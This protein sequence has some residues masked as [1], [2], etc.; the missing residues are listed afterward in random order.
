[1]SDISKADLSVRVVS[2]PAQADQSVFVVNQKVVSGTPTAG[3]VPV[4]QSDGTLAWGGPYAALAVDNTF[5]GRQ[6][7][8][9][10]S[11]AAP[12]INFAGHLTTGISYMN[13]SGSQGIFVAGNGS[14]RGVFIG[15]TD[16]GSAASIV[17]Q[18]SNRLNVTADQG[19]NVTGTLVLS[20]ADHIELEGKTPAV[21]MKGYVYGTST[22][23]P[24]EV[25]TGGAVALAVRAFGSSPL[26]EWRDQNRNVQARSRS[27][28]DLE[29]RTGRGPIVQATD[30]SLWRLTVSTTDAAAS[31]TGTVV[32]QP[33]GSSA[34]VAWSSFDD[35][36]RAGAGST[37]NLNTGQQFV[38]A[39]WSALSGTWGCVGNSGAT[40]NTATA[41]AV[42]VTD[43]GQADVVVECIV[44]L[45]ATTNRANV[46]I[47]ARAGDDSNY[48]TLFAALSTGSGNNLWLYKKVGGS[49]TQLGSQATNLFT[50]GGTYLL[51]LRCK[52]NQI[53]GYLNGTK[54][55]DVSDANALSANTAVGLFMNR[56]GNEDDGG[57]RL[58]T[59]TAV[60]A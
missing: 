29:Y 50:Q 59:F 57:S 42:A 36:Y 31:S 37:T 52:T 25:Y 16:D 26:Q 58:G 32:A 48:I 23:S 33:V 7:V 39:T 44:T 49:Y 46:G 1:M 40:L 18:G 9:V 34:A 6:T 2:N 54:K 3:Q 27:T 55:I 60:A 53:T 20:A 51:T 10:G 15:N 28:G 43:S 12:S 17:G 14:S 19:D 21:V 56:A 24:L 11:A 41:N 30:G 13:L 47:V 5:A 4:E 35:F 22:G 8:P 38:S 45:S